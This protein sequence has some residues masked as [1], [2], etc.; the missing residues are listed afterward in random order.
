MHKLPQ[1]ATMPSDQYSGVSA[2]YLIS[3]GI[4][5]LVIYWKLAIDHVLVVLGERM[6][7]IFELLSTTQSQRLADT[8]T[9]G[10]I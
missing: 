10:I 9:A 4:R 3:F 2:V 5:S 1:S 6:T 7:K 8:E